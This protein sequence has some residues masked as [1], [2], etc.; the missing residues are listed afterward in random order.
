MPL[1]QKAEI[2]ERARLLINEKLTQRALRKARAQ[3]L[4][5][6]SHTLNSSQSGVSRIEKQ[7]DLLLSI[8]RSSVE[9]I[10]G[11]LRILAEFPDQEPMAITTLGSIDP[12]DSSQK[13]N[14]ARR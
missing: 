11:K 1:D 7:T 4:S 13:K 6:I 5:K 9:E 2:R 14:R 10:G 12:L 8:L 3:M